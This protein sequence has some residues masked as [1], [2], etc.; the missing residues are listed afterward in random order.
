MLKFRIKVSYSASSSVLHV[1]FA[2][3]KNVG[4]WPEDSYKINKNKSEEESTGEAVQVT[5]VD[6]IAHLAKHKL[7]RLFGAHVLL[8]SDRNE[9]ARVLLVQTKIPEKLELGSQTLSTSSK[10]Y[11]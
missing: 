3:M 8:P 1:A 2:I 9:A 5:V 11:C 7:K 10:W 4:Y 6:L